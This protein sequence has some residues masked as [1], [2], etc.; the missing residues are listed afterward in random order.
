MKKELKDLRSF[1]SKALFLAALLFFGS[2]INF[3]SNASYGAE[4]EEPVLSPPVFSVE[5]GFY[6]ESFQ[7]NIQ[8]DE[9]DATIYYTLD[10]SLPDPANTGGKTYLYKNTWPK[11]P[12]QSFGEFLT[13][14]YKTQVYSGPINIYD[15]S[16]EDDILSLKSSSY[17]RPPYYFPSSPVFKGTVVRAMAVKEGFVQSPV[18]SHI[19]FIHPNGRQKYSIPVISIS[20]NEDNLFDYE[21]GIYTPGVDFDQWRLNNPTQQANG[22]RPAN[23]RRRSDEWEYIAHFHYFDQGSSVPNLNHEV[24]FR[25]HGGW[26]RAWPMKTLRMYARNMYGESS[27]NYP[28]FPDQDYDSYKRIILRNGGNDFQYTMFRDALLQHMV[29]HLN[30]EILAYRPTVV[31]FN[32]EYWGIHNMRERYDNHYL[33]RVFGVDTEHIDLLTFNGEVVE[34]ENTHYL[35]TLQYIRDYSMSSNSRYKHITTRIDPESFIDYQIANIYIANTDWPGNNIDFWRKRTEVYLPN[36]PYGHDGRW[37]W[38]AFDMDFGFGLY[39]TSPN[40]NTLA[41]ATQAGNWDWPNPDWSTFLL[42]NLLLNQNFRNDFINRFA[43]LLNTAFLANRVNSL[44]SEFEQNIA[45]EMPEH[46]HRWKNPW[47]INSWYSNINVMRNFAD[48]RPAYQRQ[49]ILQHFN[50][51][52]TSNFT[53]DVSNPDHGYIRINRTDVTPLTPGVTSNPYP[54]TGTYFVGVPV[55]IKAIGKE[56]YTFSHWEGIAEENEEFSRDPSLISKITAHF[57]VK[58]VHEPEKRSLVHYWLFDTGLPNNLPLNNITSHFSAVEGAMMEYH[59]SL[60]GYPYEETS[61]FW[62][63]ASLE[64]RNAPTPINYRNDGNN[65][66]PYDETEMRGIQIKQPFRGDGGDNEVI[67]HLPTNGFRDL[68][69]RFAAMDEWAVN[70]IIVEYSV[71]DGQHL[72]VTS[73]LQNHI[74]DVG[75]EYDLFTVDFSGIKETRNNPDFK[76]RLRFQCDYPPLDEGNRIIFNNISLEGNEFIVNIND[77]TNSNDF[78][79]FPNPVQGSGIV[80]L[81]NV[82]DVTIFSSFG[83]EIYFRENVQEIELPDDLSPGVYFLK[84]ARGKSAKLIVTP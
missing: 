81:Q 70:Q 63:K 73:G 56:G 59:S 40:H 47:S 6:T 36:S 33:N 83:Q 1:S 9:L 8:S 66:I 19:Y 5:S 7:L 23:Y 50:L 68:L 28:L 29:G 82:T 51:S 37:R 18:E 53:V 60:S 45:A 12:G 42:R 20:T 10:G 43:D 62:R 46:I 14:S 38:L 49:H 39:G 34:G 48:Q 24:G 4:I 79:V 64:R 32:G 3:Q 41:F 75:K 72:W 26:S 84:N 25:L 2:A 54:W 74:M 52:G 69:F 16:P 35:E 17:D 65:N 30:F 71:A 11:D 58:E 76:I 31:F 67:L 44:I 57:K 61:P 27:F 77:E 78:L 22:G 80:Y 13:G 15:R 21:L 55:T